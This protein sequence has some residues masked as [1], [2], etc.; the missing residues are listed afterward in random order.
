MDNQLLPVKPY[1]LPVW[2]HA[3]LRQNGWQFQKNNWS[4][5]ILVL[6]TDENRQTLF[7]IT[8]SKVILILDVRYGYYNIKGAE[9]SRKYTAFIT[10]YDKC[11]FLLVPFSTHAVSSYF[12]LMINETLKSLDF[13]STYLDDIILFLKSESDYLHYL[14]QSFDWL[15]QANIKLKWSNCEFFQSQIIYL[16]HLI[17]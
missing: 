8:W 15:C 10:E 13:Y 11:E 9:N 5:G 4:F 12:T 14:Y 1:T 6:H 2:H 7:N 17:S 16:W 3:W